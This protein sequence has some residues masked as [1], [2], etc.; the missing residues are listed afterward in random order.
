VVLAKL[1]IFGGGTVLL[2][3]TNVGRLVERRYVGYD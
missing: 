2:V 1:V 3:L